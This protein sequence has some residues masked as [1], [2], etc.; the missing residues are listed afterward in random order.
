VELERE[1]VAEVL[2]AELEEIA[3]LGGA[4]AV[5]QNVDATERL[6]GG[7]DDFRGRGVLAQAT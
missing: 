4:G 5:D 1:A 6:R 7:V 3:A 2:V